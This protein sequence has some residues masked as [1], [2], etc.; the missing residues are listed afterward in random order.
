MAFQFQLRRWM[1][2]YV[3]GWFLHLGCVFIPVFFFHFA[4]YYSRHLE[5]GLLPLKVSYGIAIAIIFLNT[6]TPFFTHGTA[7]RDSYAYPRPALLYPLYFL[8]FVSLVVWGTILLGRPRRKFSVVSQKRLVLFIF[9][10]ALAYLGALD[11]FLIMADIKI[12]PVYPF[13][14]YFLTPYTTIGSYVISRSLGRFA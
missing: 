13:G 6:F 14:L 11:N 12:F 1:P 7:Y 5:D 4:T 2:D 8:F 3:W 10:N 9:L